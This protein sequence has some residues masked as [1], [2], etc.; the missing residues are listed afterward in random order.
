MWP[1][2]FLIVYLRHREA[3]TKA[4]SF[5]AIG[6]SSPNGFTVDPKSAY[7][8]FI[9]QNVQTRFLMTG[10]L[11]KKNKNNIFLK[12]IP[13]FILTAETGSLPVWSG[14]TGQAPGHRS[15][16]FTF[17]DFSKFSRGFS[18]PKLS[19]PN[20]YTTQAFYNYL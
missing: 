3:A 9:D 13:C 5:V 12:S 20:L 10:L 11:S 2:F 14:E 4:S 8:W 17:E 19:S 7:Y 16:L 15:A 1:E 6:T 18:D